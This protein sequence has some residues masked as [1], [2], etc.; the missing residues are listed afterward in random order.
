MMEQPTTAGWASGASSWDR[1][2]SIGWRRPRAA[3]DRHRL[4][5]WR[6][7]RVARSEMRA[8]RNTRDRSVRGAVRICPRSASA[9]GSHVSSGRR[10]GIALRDRPVRRRRDGACAVLR[11]RSGQG[12]RRDGA[13]GPS[14]RHGLG[15]SLASRARRRRRRLRSNCAIRRH[16]G[17]AAERETPRKWRCCPRCGRM[18]A[19]RRLNSRNRGATDLRG[20]R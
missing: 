9:A 4:W 16:G 2:S 10:H 14:R 15:I 5:Q 3:M 18:R 12:R 19:W 20:F 13:R 6:L 8:S 11:S 1:S 7:H 17:A